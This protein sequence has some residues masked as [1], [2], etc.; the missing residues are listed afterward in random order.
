MSRV[1]R[2]PSSDSRMFTTKMRTA[3]AA[4]PKRSVVIFKETLVILEGRF[5]CLELSPIASQKIQKGIVSKVDATLNK[6]GLQ[7]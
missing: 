1:F 3:L 2:L 5:L 4:K 7:K 6:W